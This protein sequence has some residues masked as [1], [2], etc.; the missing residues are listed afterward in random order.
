VCKEIEGAKGMMDPGVGH[1]WNLE[2]PD[3]FTQTVRSWISEAPLPG[4]VVLLPDKEEKHRKDTCYN[5]S[6]G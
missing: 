4:E 3:L 2:A 6:M 5:E 1:A